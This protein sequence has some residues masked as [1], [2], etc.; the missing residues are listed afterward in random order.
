MNPR[1]LVFSNGIFKP[2]PH[3]NFLINVARK[4]NEPVRPIE[5]HLKNG[6]LVRV[7]NFQFKMEQPKRGDNPTERGSRIP[8]SGDTLPNG[9]WPWPDRPVSRDNGRDG[10]GDSRGREHPKPVTEMVALGKTA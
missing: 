3:D 9:R 5:Q 6:E 4:A 10:G 2:M 1:V 8:A 7:G